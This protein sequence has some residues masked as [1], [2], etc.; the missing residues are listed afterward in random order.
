MRT[1]IDYGIYF[2]DDFCQI[3]RME[4]GMPVIKHSDTMK[5]S[6]PLCVHFNKRGDVLVGDIALN[7]LKN[8]RITALKPLQ[9]GIN[10]TF[11]QFTRTLGTN[12]TYYSSNTGKSYTSE[13]LLAECF[14]MLKTF[15]Q[16][17]VVKAVVITVPAK[18]IITQIEAVRKAGKL[19]GFKQIEL[20]P[21]PLATCFGYGV[22]KGVI[23]TFDFGKSSFN[24]SLVKN[25][26][27]I[28]TDCDIWLG[29]G[30]IDEAIVDQII[31]PYLQE[32][33]A[34]ESIVEDS[35]KKEIL[36][37][38]L[39][40]FAEE[41]K[42]KLS[43]NDTHN[44]LSNMGDL[45][46]VDDNGE[47]PEIDI[48]VTQKDMEN[49]VAPIFQ[50][51]IDITKELLKRNNLK[52]SDL[53]ALILVGGPTYSP[54]LRRMLR[55]Q[56]TD[57]VDT[58]VDPM[59]VVA[60]GAALFAST[61]SVSDEVKEETRDKKKLQL[62]I[63]YE[64]ATVELEEMVN[65]KV[66]K[67][68]TVGTFPDK[69]F[70]DIVRTDGSWRSG[71]KQIG[72]KSSLVE[73]V[74]NEGQSNSFD[75]NVYD[76]A[77]NRLECQPNQFSILQGISSLDEMQVLPYHLG[78]AK[79]FESEG[80]ELFQPIKGLEKNRR[81][82]ATG[83]IFG[84]KTEFDLRPGVANDL[85]RLPIYQG[86][87]NAEGKS[88]Y[89]SNHIY[90]IIISGENL[91]TYLPAGSTI[92]FTFKVDRSQ[93]MS[94][95]AEFPEINYTNEITIDIKQPHPITIKDIEILK[96]ELVL[97]YAD[98]PAMG[99]ERFRFLLG[100]L[101]RIGKNELGQDE[102]MRIVDLVKKELIKWN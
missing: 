4:D 65:I 86:D 25:N 33:Y 6:M 90:D 58:S 16:D 100:E 99:K 3:A 66:L 91:P 62:D 12:Y 101:I 87:Y 51:A 38:A 26:T 42:I 69:V 68:K 92:N 44:I 28:D 15:V 31:I 74:L 30:N 64:A 94:V 24:V 55:D 46:F 29:G 76:E 56:I 19:A 75:I 48:T 97:F 17:E 35:T 23:L 1:H 84:F 36:R 40:P 10:N 27:I 93:L 32:T 95:I 21:E 54:I 70:V 37:N 77:G 81:L 18:F 43:F 34:I 102:K 20:I 13:E 67:E 79:Y 9:S 50:K 57:K 71:K 61:I 73:V 80:K 7:A 47:E 83:V 2:N 22:Q 78:I 41:A 5:E 8:E 60:K 89:L 88:P 82:P 39:K 96:S 59:T 49:V 14:K 85:I 45:P 98:N 52:G 53:E 63:K 11:S 72:E